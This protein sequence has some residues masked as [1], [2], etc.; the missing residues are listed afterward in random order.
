MTTPLLVLS[1]ARG[2]WLFGQAGC[3][4]Y[5][6]ITAFFGLSSM[7]YFA[8]IAYEPVIPHSAGFWTVITKR[9]TVKRQPSFFLFDYGVTHFSGV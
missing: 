7:M 8:G 1:N 2:E 3:T 9:N 6:F 4:I 5:A